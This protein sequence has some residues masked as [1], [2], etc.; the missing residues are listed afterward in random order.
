MRQLTLLDMRP[1]CPGCKTAVPVLGQWSPGDKSYLCKNCTLRHGVPIEV[2]APSGNSVGVGLNASRDYAPQ[3]ARYQSLAESLIQLRRGCV[4][5]LDTW[6]EEHGLPCEKDRQL[7]HGCKRCLNLVKYD[8]RVKMAAVT[9][10]LNNGTDPAL[11]VAHANRYDVMMVRATRPA[12]SLAFP[13]CHRCAQL[14]DHKSLSG[15]ARVYCQQ[16]DDEL[17]VEAF[18]KNRGIFENPDD[19][20]AI[21]DKLFRLRHE[22]FER[23]VL[24]DYWYQVKRRAI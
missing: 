15:D 13:L 23:G 16:C 10:A 7:R 8:T 22:L 9:W 11:A 17:E 6:T 14:H 4:M 21:L 1:V 5:T 20:E 3:R 12:F 19:D 18:V 24:P 2:F